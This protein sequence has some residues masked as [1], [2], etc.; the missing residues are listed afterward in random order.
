VDPKAEAIERIMQSR[1]QMTEAFAS[2]R[3]EPL[4][5]ANLTMSQLKALLVLADHD[6]ASGHELAAALRVGLAS[7]TGIVDRLVA[8]GLVARREDPHDRRI[9]RV[10]LTTAGRELVDAIIMAGDELQR[11]LLERLE[12]AEL[13]VVEQATQLL[14]GAAAA[15]AAMSDTTSVEMSTGADGSER[16]AAGSVRPYV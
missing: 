9:R 14:L 1:R 12:P 5:T 13:T 15:E 10:V 3:C 7:L 11:R 8:H 16:A 4:L 2:A 6:G